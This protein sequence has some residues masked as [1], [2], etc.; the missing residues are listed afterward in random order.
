MR[1]HLDDG[2]IKKIHTN[3]RLTDSDLDEL[4]SVFVAAG[5]GSPADLDSAASRAGGFAEFIRSLTGLDR[6]AA[7]KAFG[8]FLMTDTYRADQIRFVNL[9]I[10]YLTRNGTVDPARLYDSPFTDISPSGPEDLFNA[11]EIEELL[12]LL[13]TFQRGLA[14]T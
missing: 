13:D 11:D 7:K 3:Q 14:P 9:V 2:V 10:D 6:T 1:E 5:I 12:K 8:R 4:R